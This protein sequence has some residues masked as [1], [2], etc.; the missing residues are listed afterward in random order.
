ELIMVTQEERDWARYEERFKA[1]LDARSFQKVHEQTGLQKG[2]QL[3]EARAFVKMIQN[4][5]GKLHQVQTP[6]EQLLGLPVDELQRLAEQL[7]DQVS[8]WARPAN[9]ST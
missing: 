1:E 4:C 5:Q 9:G 2:L 3:G 6:A 8:S 7:L